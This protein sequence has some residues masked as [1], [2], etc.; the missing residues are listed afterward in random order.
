VQWSLRADTAAE[1]LADSAKVLSEIMAA[2]DKGI[3]EDLLDDAYCAVIV[4]GLKKGA[5][6]VGAKY[7]RGFL[8]CRQRNHGK[9][10]SPAGIRIEGGSIGWQIGGPIRMWSCSS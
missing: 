10:G 5:F 6:I 4:P 2:P 1:R 9:W 8:I 3:P 7:G